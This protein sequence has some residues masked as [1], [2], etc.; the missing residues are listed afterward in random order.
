M[1]DLEKETG[2]PAKEVTIL[3]SRSSLKGSM[4]CTTVIA[5]HLLG[6][7]GNSAVA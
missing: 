6:K 5:E 1:E 4:P 3:V 7:L 2:K